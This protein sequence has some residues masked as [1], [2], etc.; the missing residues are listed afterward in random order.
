MEGVRTPLLAEV[1]VAARF[2][3]SAVVSL[4]A[5]KSVQAPARDRSGT[6]PK[7]DDI[8]MWAEKG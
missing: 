2:L 3:D 5:S 4:A 1:C 6:V 8:Q 7:G